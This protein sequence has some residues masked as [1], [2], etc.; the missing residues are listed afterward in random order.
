MRFTVIFLALAACANQTARAA[1]PA[2]MPLPVKAQAASG[3]FLVNANFVVDAGGPPPSAWRRRLAGSWRASRGRPAS[4]SRGAL[5]LRRCQT[6]DRPMRGRAGLSH[7]RRRRILHLGRFGRRGPHQVRHRRGRHPRARHVRSID[8]A[9]ARRVSRSPAFTSRTSRGFAW[10]GL[11]LDVCRHWMPVEVIKRNL[12]AMAAVKLN[13]LHWHLSEDQGFRVESKRYPRLQQMGSD[14]PLL[15]PGPDS[16]HRALRARPRH[17]RGSGVRRPRPHRR[18]VLRR[19]RNWPPRPARSSSAPKGASPRPWIRPRRT[20][21]RSWTAS[22]ARW[23]GSFPT[24]TGTS[25]ATK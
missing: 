17:P 5:G 18:V 13:V 15:H 25:A 21:T 8:S 6:A 22:S 12:D 3:S 14:G 20:P 10:R 24:A 2:L 23:R 16:R 4:R 9:R 19:T 7:A 11:M 1:E